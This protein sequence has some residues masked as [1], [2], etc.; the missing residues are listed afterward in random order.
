MTLLLD[1][2]GLAPEARVAAIRAAMGEATVPC[3]VEHLAPPDE[4]WARMHLWSYGRTSL[5]T[6][7]AS[8]YRLVRTA[9][10]LQMESPPVVALAVQSRGY[11]RFSQ[12]GHDQVVGPRDLM[13]NDLTAPYSFSWTDAGGSRA[14]Q[15]SY[16]HLGLPVEVVRKA[17]GRVAASPL[18][19][20]VHTHLHQLVAHADELAGDASATAVGT[21]TIELVRALVV[22][23]AQ[24]DRFVPGVRA[25]TLVTRVQTYLAQHLDDIELTPAAIAA[26]HN[27]SVRQLYKAFAAA[28]LSLEQ[29][30]I[31]QRLEAARAQLRSPAGLRRSISATART[32]GFQDPSHFTR[33]FRA[34]YGLSPRDW[35]NLSR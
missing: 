32:C 30:V 3:R 7:D 26:I 5:F 14:V 31:G 34:A 29:W 17:L 18:H 23:A 9:R 13:L 6:N 20:L 27:V 11:G 28:G 19:G 22:S 8:G 35:Q 12:L 15:V 21:A 1:T 24:A 10:H 25:E 33:R 4:I 16:E 2:A